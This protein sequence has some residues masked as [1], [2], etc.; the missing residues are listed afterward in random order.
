[1]FPSL[2]NPKESRGAATGSR[3]DGRAG[4][5]LHACRPR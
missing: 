5:A 1:V 3:H 2:L 4:T